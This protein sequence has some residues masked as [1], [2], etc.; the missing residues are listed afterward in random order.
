MVMGTAHHKVPNG[1]YLRG[2]A[3]SHVTLRDE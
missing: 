1:G 2:H 3:K